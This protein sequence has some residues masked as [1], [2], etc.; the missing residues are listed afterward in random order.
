MFHKGIYRSHS[1]TAAELLN[2][3]F[4]KDDYELKFYGGAGFKTLEL[5]KKRA[6]L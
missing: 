1:G 2:K 3:V 6:G 4:K 5:V